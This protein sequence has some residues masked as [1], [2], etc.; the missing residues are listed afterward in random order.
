MRTC[1]YRLYPNRAQRQ[2]LM[3]C[4]MESRAVYNAMLTDLKAQDATDGTVPTTYDLTAR[5]K[6]RGGAA[7][8]ATTVQ[9]LADRLSKALKRFLQLKELGLPCGFP[10]CKKPTRWHSIPLR[11]YAVSRDVWLDADGTHLHVPA[12]LG[13]L[14]KIKL[15]RPIE[16]TPVTAQLV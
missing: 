1:E 15:H 3:A 8:P 13:K 7:V 9:T 12:K 2:H 14:L 4:L 10:R 16:G 11:Q 6:G 5:F